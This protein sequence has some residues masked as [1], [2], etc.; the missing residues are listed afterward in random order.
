MASNKEEIKSRARTVV[1]IFGLLF[2]VIVGRI[3]YLQSTLKKEFLKSELSNHQKKRTIAATR[4][5]IYASDGLSL[6]ATSVPKYTTIIDP[7]QA[8]SELFDKSIDSLSQCLAS[9]F[10]DKT[11]LEYKE[12]IVRARKAKNRFVQIGNRKIDH[13]EKLKILKFPLFREKPNKGGGR[14]DKEEQRFLPL[15]NLAMR[16][17][18]KMKRDEPR[19]GD[20]GIEASF[21]NY[22]KGKDGEGYYERLAGDYYK[23]MDL[24]T[25]I[26][27]E[28]GL[29]VITTLDINFQDIAESALYN[30]VVKMNAKNGSAV[31]MEIATGHIKAI[32][33]LSKYTDP[34]GVVSY[35]EDQNY[36][37]KEGSDPGSTFKLAS[38]AAILENTDMNLSDVAVNCTGEIKHA[39]RSFTCS[40]PHGSLTVQQ[41]FEKSC[42]I[43]V[44][45]LMKK[46]FGFNNPDEYF[47]YLEKF[48][49][50]QPSGFQLKGEPMPYIKT[51]KS[52]TYS[53]T[54][55]PW[56]SI[57]YESRI[58]PLQMLTFYNAIAN[59]GRWVQPII[60]KEI[61]KG[62]R[63][64]SKIEA[65]VIDQ[66]FLSAKTIA[67]L[68]TMME[69]VVLNG[70]AK[71]INNGNCRIAGKTGTAQKRVENNYTHGRYYTSFAGYFPADKPRYSC[72]VVINEPDGGNLYAAEVSAP[73]F[74]TIAEKIFSYDISLHPRFYT[75]ANTEKLAR[76]QNAGSVADHKTIASKLGVRQVPEGPG[77]SSPKVDSNK[78][79]TWKNKN[80]DKNMEAI[81]GLSLKDALPILEN[82]GFKVAYQGLGKVKAYS[83]LN[84]RNV[85]LVLN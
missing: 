33:N 8:K 7:V 29:D 30:Q 39:D 68:K 84:A 50:T 57:G 25:D 46:S 60:V 2:F 24:E 85:S 64:E 82:K 36:A 52:K 74:K 78:T 80:P 40:H 65:N 9:F 3:I 14:F 72:M 76:I 55:M 53:R 75:K 20:F 71:N 27:A 62:S 49:L 41:V 81:L 13:T 77:F 61:R 63:V 73:V 56:M 35:R 23:P 31:V 54:T 58:T 18:G 43:G 6:L 47:A 79:V 1:Y 21:E 59:N 19:K 44:Y 45:A 4:G 48:R 67:K 12:K 16:T 26:H 69:G 11:A 15:Q 34:D 22:L 51:S 28:P 17:I 70:T 83:V 10:A 38:M 37:V 66:S 32:T 42:N 5:N